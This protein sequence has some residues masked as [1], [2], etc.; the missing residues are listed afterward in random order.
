MFIRVAD[1][2]EGFFCG[3]ALIHEKYVI[4]AAHCI[5]GPVIIRNRYILDSVRLGE[6]DLRTDPDC[7][8][9]DDEER[10]VNNCIQCFRCI[11][12]ILCDDRCVFYRES[13]LDLL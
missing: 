3:G 6:H 5:R 11:Y 8:G 1:G 9:E 12:S 10:E 13:V 2:R 4:T 7:D